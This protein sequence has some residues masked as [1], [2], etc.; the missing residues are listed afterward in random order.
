MNETKKIKEML[1]IISRR[2]TDI[3]TL[4]YDLEQSVYKLFKEHYFPQGKE[5]TDF[6]AFLWYFIAKLRN[7]DL[8]GDV[9]DTIAF[10]NTNQLKEYYNYNEEE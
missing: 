8:L 10:T 7:F 1:K 4:L 9:A 3:Y 6:F 2:E 5:E